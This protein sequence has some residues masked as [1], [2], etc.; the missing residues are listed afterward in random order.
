[1]AKEWEEFCYRPK[2]SPGDLHV[3]IEQRGRMLIGK[4]VMELLGEPSTVTLH[5]C[6]EEKIIGIR[7]VHPRNPNAIRLRSNGRDK[8]RMLPAVVFCKKYEIELGRTFVFDRPE[9]EDGMLQLD[10]KAVTHIGRRGR[11]GKIK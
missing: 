9:I 5:F 3:S 11:G 1:M 4:R 6:R 8:Y 10:T 2:G 7:P